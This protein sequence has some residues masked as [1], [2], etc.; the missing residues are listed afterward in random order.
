MEALVISQQ[1]IILERLVTS[2]KLALITSIKMFTFLVQ[3]HLVSA[4]ANKTTTLV[5]TLEL[6]VFVVLINVLNQGRMSLESAGTLAAHPFGNVGVMRFEVS[7][8][9]IPIN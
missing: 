8:Y 6:T 5:A 4:F 2:I 3:V 7:C 9:L 1:R